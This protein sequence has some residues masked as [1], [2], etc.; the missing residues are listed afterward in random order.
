MKALLILACL[1]LLLAACGDDD[2]RTATERVP[3][4]I[5]SADIRIAESAPPQYYLDV[6]SGL[7]SGCAKFDRYEV[8]PA[9]D[10]IAVTIWNVVETPED[11]ACTAI[12]GYVDH[13]IPLGSSFQSGTT[14]TV[15][16]NDVTKTFVA[17]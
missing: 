4:P 2:Q 12:Y 14:Y 5:E 11:G 16:V 7:P 1:G 17:D 15:H 8:A 6:T 13:H 9:G 10:T 3:A